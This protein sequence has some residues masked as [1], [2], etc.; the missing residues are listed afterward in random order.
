MN[1]HSSEKPQEVENNWRQ[2]LAGEAVTGRGG[3]IRMSVHWVSELNP[4]FGEHSK[5]LMFL[6]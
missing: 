6:F 2:C 4:H 3:Y 1:A 5:L